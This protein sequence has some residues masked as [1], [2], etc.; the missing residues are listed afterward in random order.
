MPHR[1]L[2]AL[3]ISHLRNYKIETGDRDGPQRDLPQWPRSDSNRLLKHKRT[4]RVS[5]GRSRTQKDGKECSPDYSRVLGYEMSLMVARFIL[6]PLL[7]AGCGCSGGNRPAVERAVNS[8]LAPGASSPSRH[9]GPELTFVNLKWGP[10]QLAPG[11]TSTAEFD[12]VNRGEQPA[13]PFRVAVYA[14]LGSV[15]TANRTLLGS[16]NVASLASQAQHVVVTMTAPATAGSYAVG[17]DIDDLRQVPGD[18]RSNN[19]SGPERLI[20]K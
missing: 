1:T 9:T 13:G 11:G 8:V 18:I 6:I 17:I 15:V 12:V 14:T 4:F 19:T 10:L 3:K 5:Y 20:V 2:D 16:A 7:L